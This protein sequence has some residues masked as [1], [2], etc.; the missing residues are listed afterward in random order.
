MTEDAAVQTPATDEVVEKEQTQA[1]VMAEAYDRAMKEPEE[2]P[3]PKEAIKAEE[4]PEPEKAEVEA[5]TDLPG[6]VKAHWRDI[7]KA[8]REALV[9]S[10]REM[11]NKL[12]QANRDLQGIGPIRDVVYRAARE[13]PGIKEM[14]PQQISEQLWGL[15]QAGQSLQKDPEAAFLGL[16]RQHN[17]DIAKLAGKASSQPQQGQQ[18]TEELQVLR[19]Q[20][21]QANQK[22]QQLSQVADP[23][24]LKQQ[25]SQ[26][27]RETSVAQEVQNFAASQEHWG[28]VEQ[29]LPQVIPL[30]QAKLGQNAAP[31][32]V[33]Q[34]AYELAV[35]TFVPDARARAEGAGVEPAPQAPQRVQTAVKAKSV[36]VKSGPSSQNRPANPRDAMAAVYDRMMND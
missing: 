6:G 30:A 29:Y 3:E 5:P 17:I 22:I 15:F 4:E 24:Y 21:S 33:L 19:Q 31:K 12:S 26:F 23:N 34:M 25:F 10:Q 18:G 7:P 36:N 20:L 9:S 32:E 27:S 1:E 16:A 35:N 2:A 11:A 28:A 8:A 13:M 14:T